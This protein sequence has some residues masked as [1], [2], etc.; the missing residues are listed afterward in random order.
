M[1]QQSDT[2]V[3]L[4]TPP[5]RSGIGVI[6]VSGSQSLAILRS[7]LASPDSNPTPNNLTLRNL[8]DP[9]TNQ[10]LDQA[11]VCYFKAPH[12]FTGEDVVEFH[13]HGSP[14]LLRAIIDATLNLEARMASP[15]EFS[16]RAVA[17]GRMKLSEAEAIR[18][19]IDAQTDAA[20]RQATRQMQ[21]AISTALQLMR[22][23]RVWRLP[24]ISSDGALSGIVTLDDLALRTTP[25]GGDGP[26]W[27]E[28][29]T[30]LQ[31][32]CE[33]QRRAPA[34]RPRNTAGVAARY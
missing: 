18:D 6:R 24:V 11:M 8:F 16:L 5:G 13:C 20:I 28:L 23:W 17:N 3:A 7:L 1:V 15:G 33:R 32:I 22:R 10:I 9:A 30:T 26:S 25:S 19:L 2:I 4:A 31:V 34:P 14:V 12:S 29:V 27:S 21:G